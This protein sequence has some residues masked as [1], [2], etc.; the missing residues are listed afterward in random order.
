MKKSKMKI[1]K[2]ERKDAHFQ[3]EKSLY[4]EFEMY[5]YENG[6]SVSEVLRSYMKMCVGRI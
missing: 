1:N 5:C 6:N 2:P 3:C 4:D